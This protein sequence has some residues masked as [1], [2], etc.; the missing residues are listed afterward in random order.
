M[1]GKMLKCEIETL[2]I[3]TTDTLIEAQTR[4]TQIQNEIELVDRGYQ[5]DETAAMALTGSGVYDPAQAAAQKAA[6]IAAAAPMPAKVSDSDSNDGGGHGEDT[7]DLG[8]GTT[9]EERDAQQSATGNAKSP[10]LTMTYK[11]G[12]WEPT[13]QLNQV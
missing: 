6:S 12:A 3:R 1:L 13:V 2:P 10:P 8:P 9:K 7:R 11:N 4:V 5:S